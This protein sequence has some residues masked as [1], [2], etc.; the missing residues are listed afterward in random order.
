MER[1]ELFRHLVAIAA[2][3]GEFTES[4]V[5]MLAVR[6]N[7]WDITQQQFDQIITEIQAGEVH[8]QLPR[9]LDEKVE[10]LKNMMHM[11]AIDGELAEEEKRMCAMASARMGFTA[12]QFDQ[13]LDDLLKDVC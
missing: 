3:D 10:L 7:Q 2:S 12:E 8:L 1:I 13:I 9:E 11:M 6:A 5:Q 4:E